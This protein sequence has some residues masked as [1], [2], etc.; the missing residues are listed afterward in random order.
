MGNLLSRQTN[1]KV[2]NYNCLE[3]II[4]AIEERGGL[5]VSLHAFYS[6]ILGSNLA[7]K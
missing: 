5:V 2:I 6:N 7:S 3:F 1:S 4:L